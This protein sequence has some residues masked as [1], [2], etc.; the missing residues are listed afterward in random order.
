MAELKPC[1]DCGGNDIWP[2][3]VVGQKFGMVCDGCGFR[4]PRASDK[5]PDEAMEA[6]NA[7]PG[8]AP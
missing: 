6:W 3:M 8:E 1:P 5:D 7:L 4:G 2:E